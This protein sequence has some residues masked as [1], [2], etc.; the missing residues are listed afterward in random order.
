MTSLSK[1]T[2]QSATTD[3][4]S[5]TEVKETSLKSTTIP[6]DPPATVAVKEPVVAAKITPTESGMEFLGAMVPPNMKLSRSGI[7]LVVVAFRGQ[8]PLGVLVAADPGMLGEPLDA[9]LEKAGYGKGL[10]QRRAHEMDAP[11]RLAA[12]RAIARCQDTNVN[13]PDAVTSLGYRYSQL[14]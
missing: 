4:A 6:S 5:E 1:K 14:V 9:L 8:Q 11:T 2:S 13:K 10:I 12:A 7:S 3:T